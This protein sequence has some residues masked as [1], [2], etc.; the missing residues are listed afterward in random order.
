MSKSKILAEALYQNNEGMN[1]ST[2]A[3]GGGEWS[4]EVTTASGQFLFELVG[5]N[6]TNRDFCPDG[7][8]SDLWGEL[9]EI[10]NEAEGIAEKKGWKQERQETSFV[11]SEGR[12]ISGR[13]LSLGR[14]H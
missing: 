14:R 10:E 4:I 13:S 1:T 3:L 11:P 9:R 12:V 5:E 6:G 7:E 8:A 2:H